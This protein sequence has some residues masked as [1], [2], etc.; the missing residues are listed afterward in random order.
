M[1]YNKISIRFSDR[2]NNDDDEDADE[3]F[4]YFYY[5]D[6]FGLELFDTGYYYYYYHSYLMHTIDLI[7][8]LEI[9]VM[10][11]HCV[12]EHASNCNYKMYRFVISLKDLLFRSL[13]QRCHL[14]SLYTLNQTV[15]FMFFVGFRGEIITNEMLQIQQ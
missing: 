10:M 11:I 15:F 2:F 4:S 12:V 6:A 8:M 5:Y 7:L 13:Q 9:V 14:N 3:P 1:W